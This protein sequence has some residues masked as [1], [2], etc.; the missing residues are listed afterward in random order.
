MDKQ[1]AMRGQIV[2]LRQLLLIMVVLLAGSSDM[3]AE[4]LLCPH[5]LPRENYL[6]CLDTIIKRPS[7]GRIDMQRRDNEAIQEATRKVQQEERLNAIIDSVV[8]GLTYNP[9]DPLQPIPKMDEAIKAVLDALGACGP[10]CEMERASDRE[11]LTK[12]IL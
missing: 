11:Y 9:R 5:S 7:P 12:K 6:K 10:A 2:F 1:R 4:D 3:L 8:T